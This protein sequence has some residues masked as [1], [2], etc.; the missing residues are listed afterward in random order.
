MRISQ[1]SSLSLLLLLVWSLPALSQDSAPS[2][3]QASITDAAPA[4]Q[5]PGTLSSSPP[6]S[7]NDVMDRVVQG[8]RL[9]LG[10]VL[11]GRRIVKTYLLNV[12]HDKI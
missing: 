4:G 9:F 1:V 6:A 3:P 5:A 7:F 11:G 12:T 10:V 2:T 8:E